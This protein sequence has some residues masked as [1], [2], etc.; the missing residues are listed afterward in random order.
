[1]QLTDLIIKSEDIEN[2]TLCLT[3]GNNTLKNAPQ[4]I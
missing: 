2:Q 3:A 4:G 1:M